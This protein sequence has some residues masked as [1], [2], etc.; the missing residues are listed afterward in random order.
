MGLG[1]VADLAS[2]Y[3]THG[4]E[5]VTS[6]FSVLTLAGLEP[7]LASKPAGEV[8]LG[9][10]LA[11]LGIPLGLFGLWQVFRAV[12]PAG[13]WL[14]RGVWFLGVMGFVVGTTFHATFAFVTFGIQAAVATVPA[15][16]QE[17]MLVRFGLVF[18]PLAWL[19][20]GVMGVAFGLIFVA[21]AFRDTHYPRWFAV[22][23]PLL[24]QAATGAVALVAPLE[25]RVF[26]VVTSYNLSV[27]V[28]FAL[29]TAL[30]WN[31]RLQRRPS[32]RYDAA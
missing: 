6:A 27:L 18:E 12:E 26:F 20:L 3:S 8:I 25:I 29:S 23:N 19:L 4:A 22:A 16:A 28:F 9:H 11:V 30:L 17:T 7:F 1:V 14:S 32:V 10:Y 13:W 24:I 21:I 5:A 2:G 31:S 15:A